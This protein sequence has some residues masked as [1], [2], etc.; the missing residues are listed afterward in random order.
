MNIKNLIFLLGVLYCGN[1]YAGSCLAGNDI[2]KKCI[3]NPASACGAIDDVL[4]FDWDKNGSINL[5]DKLNEALSCYPLSI[6]NDT[7]PTMNPERY[8]QEDVLLKLEQ[9]RNDTTMKEWVMRYVGP[10]LVK[11]TEVR[12]NA[13]F[14]LSPYRHSEAFAVL[15]ECDNAWGLALLGDERAID[16]FENYFTKYDTTYKSKP[17]FA[18]PYK[19]FA[20][21]A[22]GIIGS[23]KALDFLNQQLVNPRNKDLVADINWVIKRIELRKK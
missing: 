7:P 15:K 12:C 14:Q 19:Q 3:E 10:L 5:G 6:W 4:A 17:V 9:R 20:L 18:K 22:L 13:A 1:T 23:P 8:L 21:G 16:Y 2:Y 11:H